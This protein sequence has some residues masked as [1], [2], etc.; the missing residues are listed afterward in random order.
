[1]MKSLVLVGGSSAIGKATAEI[2]KSDYDIFV[3][4]RNEELLNSTD[5]HFWVPTEG[6]LAPLPEKIDGL[7]YLPGTI[8][9]KPFNRLKDEDFLIDY[10]VNFLCAVRIIRQAL[11]KLLKSEIASVVAIS[12]VAARTGMNFHTSISSAKG[13]LE[14]LII[15]LAAEYAG[16]IRFNAVAPSLTDTPLSSKFLTNDEK[17]ANLAKNNPMNKIGKAEEVAEAIAFLISQKSSWING[18]IIAVDGG[19]GN[20]K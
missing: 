5:A 12:T 2:L 19:M 18:Q 9:L 11:P 3:L 20:L 15:S 7:V 17:R 10:N 4:S 14:S 8:N 16:K 6:N 13:A 1:M